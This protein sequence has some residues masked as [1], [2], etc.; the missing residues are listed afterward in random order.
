MGDERPT[1][2][3]SRDPAWHSLAILM[4]TAPIAVA[5]L[6]IWAPRGIAGAILRWIVQS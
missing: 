4:A 5:M 3:E 1:R 2:D 6:P